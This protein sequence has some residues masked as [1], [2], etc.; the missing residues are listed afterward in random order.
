MFGPVG[1]IKAKQTLSLG[2][3][4]WSLGFLAYSHSSSHLLYGF[5][6]I[7]E[8]QVIQLFH[9]FFILYRGCLGRV[10]KVHHLAA[11]GA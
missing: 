8:F 11:T 4:L 9:V 10:G 1:N 2:C 7:F 6:W 5:F 3:S